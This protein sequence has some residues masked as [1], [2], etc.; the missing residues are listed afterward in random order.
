MSDEL[1]ET[2]AQTDP[3]WSV[4]TEPQYKGEP[5]PDELRVFFARGEKYVRRVSAAFD[6]YFDRQ[7]SS[8]DQALDFGSGVGRLLLPMAKKCGHVIGVDI[9]PTMRRIAREN[10]K[11]IK[12][13]NFM[14]ISNDQI[15]EVEDSTIDWLNSFITFQHIDTNIGYKIFDKLLKKVSPNG[16]VSMHFTLFKDTRKFNYIENNTKYFSSDQDGI[17][18]IYAPND[19]YDHD[20]IMMNDYDATKII[21]IF[22]QNGFLTMVAEMEDQDGMHGAIFYAIK[23]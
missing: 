6:R 3:Y 11:R 10:A 4:L 7:I 2:Y 20:Q 14:C 18:K 19:M 8:A 1:W 12:I 21:M 16:V 5:G 9:S 23:S 13:F 22:N 17:R 15:D